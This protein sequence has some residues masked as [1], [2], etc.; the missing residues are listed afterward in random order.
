MERKSSFLLLKGL[1]VSFLVGI[2]FFLLY[3]FVYRG[4]ALFGS[5]NFLLKI[6]QGFEISKNKESLNSSPF[7]FLVPNEN[8]SSKLLDVRGRVLEI[9]PGEFIKVDDEVS[10]R[11]KTLDIASI[12]SIYYK[13]STVWSTFPQ[14]Q[15]ADFSDITEGSLIYFHKGAETLYILKE[16]FVE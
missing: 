14:R 1:F 8:D 6:F 16:D 15:I 7:A 4:S 5:E 3:F 11:V 10:G 2:V 12:N 9:D 13:F